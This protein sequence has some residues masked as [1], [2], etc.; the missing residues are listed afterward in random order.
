MDLA[1]LV[2][3]AS[4]SANTDLMGKLAVKSKDKGQNNISFLSYFVLG[5]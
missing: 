1:G 2:L 5:R 4:A 3:L